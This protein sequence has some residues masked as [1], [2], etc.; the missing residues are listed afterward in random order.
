MA[1]LESIRQQWSNRIGDRSRPIVLI[2]QLN[3]SHYLM[4]TDVA[5]DLC[6][7]QFASKST[8]DRKSS[9]FAASNSSVPHNLAVEMSDDVSF[10]QYGPRQR[11]EN[12]ADS[13]SVA[14]R[15]TFNLKAQLS[16]A[17]RHFYIAVPQKSRA[18]WSAFYFNGSQNRPLLRLTSCKSDNR[19]CVCFHI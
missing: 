15:I 14:L 16:L 8:A 18:E 3:R 5:S 9:F 4:R 10:V 19:N 6:Q 7:H 11:I 1:A 2:G 17:G 12:I 13:N